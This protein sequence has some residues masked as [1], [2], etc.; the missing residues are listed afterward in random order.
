MPS[1]NHADDVVPAG[2]RVQVRF[3][4]L[5][6]AERTASLP[7]DTARVPYEARVRGLLTAPGRTGEQVTV[8]T[9]AGRTMVG[10]LELVEP[11][12]LHTFGRPPAA[13]V[14]AVAPMAELLGKP[15]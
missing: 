8:R 15:A 11:A 6:P 12:D 10:E 2:T 14:E 3:V 7:E 1:G 5:E 4:V 13:L 9:A